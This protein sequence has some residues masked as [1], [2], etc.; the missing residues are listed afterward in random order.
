MD[1]NKILEIFKKTCVEPVKCHPENYNLNFPVADGMHT[2]NCIRI[3][4]LK[5]KYCPDNKNKKT[6]K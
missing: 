5:E 1:C 4:V 2:Q 6:K 3:M